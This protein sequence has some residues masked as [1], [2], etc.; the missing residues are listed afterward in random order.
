MTHASRVCVG[1]CCMRH[2]RAC[3]DSATVD[4]TA[5]DSSRA[6][7]IRIVFA[8]KHPDRGAALV[9]G[10]QVAEHWPN[11]VML[12]GA[13]VFQACR[14]LS[15][16][17]AVGSSKQTCARRSRNLLVIHLKDLSHSLFDSLPY[18]THVLDPIDKI[19]RGWSVPADRRLCGLLT[20]SEAQAALY[21]SHGARRA[22]V[23][24]DHGLPGCEEGSGGGSSSS[25][26][27]GLGDKFL[28]SRRIFERRTVLVL[29]G[30]PSDP[31][32]V[33]LS[34]WA[35]EQQLRRRSSPVTVLY[36]KDLRSSIAFSQS[37]GWS[38]W[39]CT[40]LRNNVSIAVAWDQIS[41]LA[42]E[43]DC[44]AHMGLGRAECLALKPAERFIVPQSA[45]VPAIGY[46]YP[47]FREAARA[48]V[49]GAADVAAT[50]SS[51][52]VSDLLLAGT[53][54]GLLTRLTWLTSN[55]SHWEHA[56]AHGRAVGAAHSMRAV[57]AAYERVRSKAMRSK[58]P[59]ERC[60]DS[61][62]GLGGGLAIPST[63]SS[64]KRARVPVRRPGE[65]LIP[66]P[67]A[68]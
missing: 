38:A 60:S 44:Q 9:R 48:G 4:S 45:G 32:R 26:S 36:E 14:I 34:T 15:G 5:I 43:A 54:D 66:L 35:A 33:G 37:A 27:S 18:A 13:R 50:A 55:H 2:P 11:A 52:K 29:G 64:R 12:G 10:T 19:Y 59:G 20:H 42:F 7:N 57:T 46:R 56:R 62:E 16:G 47:S 53:I 31:L 39:L 63:R 24:P 49:Y 65:H 30:A 17:S 3:T 67:V 41:G 40:L 58:A 25:S 8:S 6:Q 68:G 23:A 22:W 51:S 28:S 1:V 61:E 21:R